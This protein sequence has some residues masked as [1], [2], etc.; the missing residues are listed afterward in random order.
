MAGKGKK[1]LAPLSDADALA[2]MKLG[3]SLYS[4]PD[5]PLKSLPEQFVQPPDTQKA[6]DA[7]K[8]IFEAAH[9]NESRQDAFQR[10]AQRKS[11]NETMGDFIDLVE[12]GSKRAPNLLSVYCFDVLLQGKP[13]AAG[14]AAQILVPSL[15]LRAE[16]KKQGV[17]GCKVH[18]GVKKGLEVQYAYEDPTNEAN[19]QHNDAY[20]N[21]NFIMGGLTS[22]RRAYVRGRYIYSKGVKGPWSEMVSIMVP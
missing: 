22:G 8:A 17:V 9:P 5:S 19:W 3:V 21:A 1:L 11:Y 10:A 18:G 20:V 7:F 16:D 6:Y 4:S 2:V 15:T 12:V 13:K 14:K